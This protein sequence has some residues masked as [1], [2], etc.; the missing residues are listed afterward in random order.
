MK[1]KA[2]PILA[3]TA[4][5]TVTG[6]PAPVAGQV[7]PPPGGQRQRLELEQRLQ[8]GFYRQVQTQLQLESDQV[9]KLQ[10]VTR[11]FQE[12]R[13]TL[14]RSMASL[15]YKLRDPGLVDMPEEDARTL[16]QEMVTLQEQELGLYKREQ[17]ELLEVITPVQL[18]RL[19][20]L[21]DD[22]GQRVQ[23]LRQGRGQGAGR[24]GGGGRDVGMFDPTGNPLGRDL[25]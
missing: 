9:Q 3:L 19:Y 25:R 1:R 8:R 7:T 24:G 20:R 21:R 6:H 10:D 11:S 12:E 4:A 22:L 23:Q 14:N 5:L 18:I 15:R 2:I 16:L 17:A 13:R